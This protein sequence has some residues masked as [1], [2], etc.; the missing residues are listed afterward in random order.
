MGGKTRNTSRVFISFSS[1]DAVAKVTKV[2]LV[3]STSLAS[4]CCFASYCCWYSAI[5]RSMCGAG[6]GD[7]AS[8]ARLELEGPSFQARLLDAVVDRADLVLLDLAQR[9]AVAR[10]AVHQRDQALPGRRRAFGDHLVAALQ[11]HGRPHQRPV[12]APLDP[13]DVGR[14][15]AG[16][17][18][19]LVDPLEV[20]PEEVAVADLELQALP[21]VVLGGAGRGHRL[22]RHDLPGKDGAVAQGQLLDRRGPEEAETV[23]QDHDDQAEDHQEARSQGRSGEPDPRVA[24]AEH[25]AAL[26][27]RRVLRARGGAGDARRPAAGDEGGAFR[28]GFGSGLARGVAIRA[29]GTARAGAG[30]SPRRWC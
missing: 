8:L 12:L 18:L 9:G 27:P 26:R 30:G 14:R 20:E 11:A 22:P 5:R 10:R 19:V 28:D 25:A 7:V 24:A 2:W 21:L 1:P 3:C 13:G 4:S 15:L 29:P 6:G 17:D 23:G 16:R